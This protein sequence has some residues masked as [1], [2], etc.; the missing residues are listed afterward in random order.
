M[1]RPKLGLIIWD[2]A[3]ETEKG[4]SFLNIYNKKKKKNKQTNKVINKGFN[5]CILKDMSS[6]GTDL[7][8]KMR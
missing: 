6:R 4:V 3:S 1:T 7:V 8:A 5:L 2:F